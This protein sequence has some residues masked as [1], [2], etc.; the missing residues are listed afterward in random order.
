MAGPK[1]A[2][3]INAYQL[4]DYEAELRNVFPPDGKLVAVFNRYHQVMGA[5]DKPCTTCTKKRY[6]PALATFFF[7][8]IARMSP[9]Q[10]SEVRSALSD[11]TAV[12]DKLGDPT[13]L[14]ALLV[15]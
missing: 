3:A 14:D 7:A 12:R 13:D 11:V 4:L 10:K 1:V 5:T 2:K 15:K 9:E 8:E 6:G